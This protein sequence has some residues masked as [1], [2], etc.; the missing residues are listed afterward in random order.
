VAWLGFDHHNFQLI[1][2][3]QKS[4]GEIHASST[5]VRAINLHGQSQACQ[6]P[7][8]EDR[9]DESVRGFTWKIGM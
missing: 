9:K 3:A 6:R 5:V 2:F 8:Y 1:I 7:I 4:V